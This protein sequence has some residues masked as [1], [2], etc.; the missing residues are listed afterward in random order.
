MR[1]FRFYAESLEGQAGVMLC[2]V[3]PDNLLTRQIHIF[4]DYLYWAAPG[5]ERD[6]RYPFT[7]QPEFNEAV[8]ECEEIGAAEFLAVWQRAVQQ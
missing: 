2:E 8:E 4:G 3:S 6:E 5:S 7:D 1:Y